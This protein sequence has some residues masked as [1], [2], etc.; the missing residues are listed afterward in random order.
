MTDLT[1][2]I[3]FFVGI[4]EEL[5]NVSLRR[6]KEK[7][8]RNVLLIFEKLKSLEKFKSYTTQTYGD[9]RLIDSEGEISVKPS[10]L[11]IIWGGD[12]GDDLKQVECG[13]EIEQ[14]DHWERFMRF[15]TRYA[16][17]NGMSYQDS[18]K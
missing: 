16:E 5:S 12:E 1:P 4:S 3:E 15:M 7:G 10:S 8:I 13:F 2:S 18:Q 11:R 17:A 9:L 14:D 6:S